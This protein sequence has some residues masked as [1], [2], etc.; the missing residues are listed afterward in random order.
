M[1]LPNKQTIFN[2]IP[3]KMNLKRKKR[4]Y[5]FWRPPTYSNHQS[6]VSKELKFK[7]PSTA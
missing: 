7:K 2:R 1:L 6:T 3:Q 5:N 4:L